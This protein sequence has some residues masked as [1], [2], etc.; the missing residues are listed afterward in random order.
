MS[1]TEKTSFH[2]SN[3]AKP[4]PKNLLM[5]SRLFQG[6]LIGISTLGTFNSWPVWMVLTINISI[7]TVSQLTLFFGNIVEDSKTETGV[8]EMPSGKEVTVT[9]PVENTPA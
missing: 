2:W 9:L 7:I 5:L 4:T 8:A 6:I 3:Y 1:I